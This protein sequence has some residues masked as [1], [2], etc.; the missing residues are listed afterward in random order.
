MLSED[1]FRRAIGEYF[2]EIQ[3]CITAGFNRWFEIPV[4]FRVI[5]SGRT[6][7]SFIHDAIKNEAQSRFAYVPSIELMEVRN[8]FLIKFGEEVLLRFK[9]FD[10]RFRPQNIPTGQTR[11]FSQQGIQESLFG[12]PFATKVIA[13]YQTDI[14]HAEIQ[15]TGITCPDGKHYHWFI[16]FEKPS[17]PIFSFQNDQGLSEETVSG[18]EPRPKEDTINEKGGDENI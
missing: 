5:A 16:N 8:L 7:A 4:E 17:T 12:V 2:T 13:G 10:K 3:D 11:L 6:R 9:K 18:T 1:D 15:W 14:A